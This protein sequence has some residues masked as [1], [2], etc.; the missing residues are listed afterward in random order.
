M[1][2]FFLSKWAKLYSNMT[3]A[4][5]NLEP[6]IAKLGVRY[7][8]QHPLWALRVFPDFALPDQRVVIEVDDP[9]HTTKSARLK[10]AERTLKIERAGWKVVRC[11]ND[12]A[13]SDPIGTVNRL[14]TEAHFPN[15]QVRI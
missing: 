5:R 15:L 2:D 1:A 14:M 10:D 6:A 12:D 13:L 11:T 7:R 8:C 4:E 9:S 3:P